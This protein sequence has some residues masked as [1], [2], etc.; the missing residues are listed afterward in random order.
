VAA[1]TRYPLAEKSGKIISGGCE[2]LRCLIA[3]GY[4]IQKMDF[5]MC[6]S[7]HPYIIKY[8]GAKNKFSGHLSRIGD[9]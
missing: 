3:R 7:N 2:K 5:A 1:G 9:C 6:L 8:E 4:R